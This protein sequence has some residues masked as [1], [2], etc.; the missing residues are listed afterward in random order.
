MNIVTICKIDE[1]IPTHLA[2]FVYFAR[3]A[4]KDVKIHVAI[5]T[6]G[7][8]EEV[9]AAVARPLRAAGLNL[10][11]IKQQDVAGRLL[12]FD[13][14]RSAA[15]ELFGLDECLYADPDIDIVEDIS[16]ITQY[17]GDLL[18][19]PNPITISHLVPQ[20][21]K[22]NLQPPYMEPGFMYMRSSFKKDFE[23]WLN[24][25]AIDRGSFAPGSVIWS[26]ISAGVGSPPIP[27][28]YNVTGWAADQLCTAKSIHFTGPFAKQWRP[29]ISY[30]HQPC[31]RMIINP[32]PVEDGIPDLDYRRHL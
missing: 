11:F 28:Y 13:M 4:V 25:P 12:Y 29:Y 23:K 15:T 10:R 6:R 1:W 22:L 9:L 7:E 31:R 30:E 18:W 14:L 3:Q 32:K 5:P 27:Q 19:V 21:K 8:S 24:D 20:F 2:R 17:D 26:A 16:D